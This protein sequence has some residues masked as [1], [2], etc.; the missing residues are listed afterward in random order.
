MWITRHGEPRELGNA[1]EARLID[2]VREGLTNAAKHSHGRV[3]LVH[4]AYEEAR[5][6]LSL[7]TELGAAAG[8][9]WPE[10]ATVAGSGLSLL[11]ERTE[12]LGGALELALGDDDVAV[13]RVE[14]PS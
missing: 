12:R 1:T 13:L 8:R 4:L 6:L 14:V 7:Q 11:R 2:S 3:V 5:V 10:P 9:P